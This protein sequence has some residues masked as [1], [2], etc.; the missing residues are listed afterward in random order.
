MKKGSVGGCF[1]DR[2]PGCVRVCIREA[3]GLTDLDVLSRGPQ[4]VVAVTSGCSHVKATLTQLLI[5]S[6]SDAG[7]VVLT[8]A[9]SLFH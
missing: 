6:L 8:E 2:W 3:D 1:C 4:H 9:Q 5:D 7:H